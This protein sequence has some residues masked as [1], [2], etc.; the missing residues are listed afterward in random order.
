MS[1]D[2]VAAAHAHEPV[3]ERTDAVERL[4]SDA[5]SQLRAGRGLRGVVGAAAAALA[6]PVV[7]VSRRRRVVASAGLG[8]GVDALALVRAATL[9]VPVQV[10]GVPWGGLSV[11]G[12]APPH[13]EAALARAAE[14]VE[15]ELLHS[16]EPVEAEQ[17]AQRELFADL[18]AGRIAAPLAAARAGLLGRALGER[19]PLLAL[20]ASAAPLAPHAVVSALDEAGAVGVWARLDAELLVLGAGPERERTA[21]TAAADGLED[22]GR[23]LREARDALAVARALGDHRPVVHAHELLVD[24][25]LVQVAGD[26]DLADALQEE[27]APLAALPSRTAETLLQTLQAYL[28]AGGSKTLAAQRLRV[29][30]QSLYRRLERI[31]RLL[32][33]LDDP[34]RRLALQLAARVARLTAPPRNTPARRGE[35]W[36]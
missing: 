22:A 12:D 11:A 17:R 25:L 29:R 33:S 4:T 6:L 9:T 13:A 18:L 34:E 20:A 35:R 5:L 30:R 28:D 3:E 1:I 10:R 19:R 27:L 32:G 21:A 8:A 14:L 26:R 15:L 31:E 16:S 23:R 2:G 7:L 36:R 24:R